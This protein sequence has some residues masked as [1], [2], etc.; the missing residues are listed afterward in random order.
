MLRKYCSRY[1][2]EWNK[3]LLQ[4]MGAY[5]SAQHSTTGINHFMMLTGRERAINLMLFYPE[6]E[7]Q[8]TSPQTYVKEAIK[9]QQELNELCSRNTA[10]S[11]MRQTKIIRFG[12]ICLGDSECH[13]F[14]KNKKTIEEMER[15]IRDNKSALAGSFLTLEYRAR[16]AL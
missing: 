13:P 3:Y 8:R 5:N 14:K 4:V 11:Q 12:K 6:Y 7:G 16:R 10:Q 9:S 2:R 1:M 15:T